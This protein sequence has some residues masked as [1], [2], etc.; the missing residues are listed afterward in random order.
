MARSDGDDGARLWRGAAGA[1][2]LATQGWLQPLGISRWS[3]AM[4]TSQLAA[5]PAPTPSSTAAIAQTQGEMEARVW[6]G[7]K[8]SWTGWTWKRPPHRAMLPG[9]EA[10]LWPAPRGA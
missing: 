9:A 3:P 2:T 6:R 7:W 5:P 4:L 8:A 1:L 10:L